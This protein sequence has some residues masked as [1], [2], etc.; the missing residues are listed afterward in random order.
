[1]GFFTPYSAV[2]L[3]TRHIFNY[4]NLVNVERAEYSDK[5]DEGNMIKMNIVFIT[6]TFV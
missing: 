6:R 1:M 5:N 4:W 2:S 3:F